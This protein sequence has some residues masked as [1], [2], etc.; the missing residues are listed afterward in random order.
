MAT[1]KVP[2][3]LAEILTKAHAGELPAVHQ[4]VLAAGYSC[5]HIVATAHTVGTYFGHH[6]ATIRQWVKTGCPMVQPGK[7]G[8]QLLFDIREVIA[9]R[10][11]QAE[12]KAAE[13]GAEDGSDLG[14][15]R[16]ALAN[17]AELEYAERL[18]AVVRKD[19]MDRAM[20]SF[21]RLVMSGVGALRDT[22]C[23]VCPDREME[24]GR[25]VR[26]FLA[27]IRSRLSGAAKG[28]GGSNADSAA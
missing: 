8:R 15:R 28:R 25:R 26:D 11:A 5:G 6:E 20:D 12:S 13:A 21:V 22:L 16:S 24:I 9:W 4:A 14:R 19:D 3:K 2:D 7:S 10:L 17:L 27:K 23:Q 18:G 1:A